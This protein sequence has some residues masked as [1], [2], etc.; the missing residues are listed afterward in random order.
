MTAET[1]RDLLGTIM[2]ALGADLPADVQI[3]GVGSLD[4]AFRVTELAAASIAAAGVAVQQL[5][6]STQPIF[7]NR[8][9]ASHWFGMSLRPVG[10]ELPPLWDTVA[11]DY[12]ASDGWIRLHTNAAHHRAAA[13]HVL[14]VAEDRAAVAAAVRRW[15]ADELEQAVVTAGGAAAAMHSVADWQRHPQGAA[16]RAEP[17]VHRAATGLAQPF[18]RIHAESGRPLGGVRVLDLTRVLA[19]PVATRLLAGWGGDVLR[20]DPPG[21][22]EPG[23]IPEV[24]LGKRTARLDLRSEA[25]REQF[26]RLLA[27]ADVLVHGYRADALER[28]GLGPDVRDAVRPGL[29]DVAL[30]AYGWT[31]PWRARRG[32]DSLVQMSSG[33]AEAGMRHDG[34]DRPTPLPVQALD[35]ATGYLIAAA[36]IRGLA[37]REVSGRGSRWRLSLARTAQLLVDAGPQP[38]GIDPVAGEPALGDDIELTSWGPARRVAAPIDVPGVSLRWPLPARA[39]GSDAARW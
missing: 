2:A 39:L 35:H 17:L 34:R 21:W 14:G 30:N 33:I 3:T 1:P 13:L 12:E 27:S 25:G 4:S 7:V 19:G 24:L 8:E 38:A 31:G 10:W 11:G 9:L 5:I 37:E 23:V 32:F 22:D 15:R 36:A 26:T 29:I 6:G 18:E 20:I 28:L 16:V